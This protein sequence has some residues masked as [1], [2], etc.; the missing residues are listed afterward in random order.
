M[1]CPPTRD[2]SEADVWAPRALARG[3]PL[4]GLKHTRNPASRSLCFDLSVSATLGSWGFRAS[5]PFRPNQSLGRSDPGSL[6]WPWGRALNPRA[7]ACATGLAPT[8]S[9]Q[10]AS[11]SP[12][13]STGLP[14]TRPSKLGLD[15][16]L[17]R[18]PSG[19]P[20]ARCGALNLESQLSTSG[21]FF[22]PSFHWA[23]FPESCHKLRACTPALG[24]C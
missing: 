13:L 1:L 6:T 21:D 23:K 15:F 8:P 16:S 2:C 10:A 5:V 22:S 19:L 12:G 7:Q 18:A 17:Q 24:V 14:D 4:M 3:A 11:A 20:P 9:L